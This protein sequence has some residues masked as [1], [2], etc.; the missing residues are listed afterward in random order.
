MRRVFRLFSLAIFLVAMSVCGKYA[1]ATIHGAAGF[2]YDAATYPGYYTCS[3]M[4]TGLG[5]KPMFIGNVCDLSF[6]SNIYV[7]HSGNYKVRAWLSYGEADDSTY[8]Y[9]DANIPLNEQNVT[10]T[11]SSRNLPQS[12]VHSNLDFCYYLIDESGNLYGNIK[13][14]CSGG[15]PLPP[16]PPVP[17]TS[18]SINNGNSLN[19]NLGTVERA[20]LITVPGTGSIQHIQIPVDCTGG[21]NVPVNMVI[22]YTPLTVSGT[23]IVKTSSNGLGVSIIY[24]NKPISTSDNTVI[25]FLSGSNVLD[26]GFE[27]VRDP[28]VSIADVPTG[29]FTASATI[30]MTQQ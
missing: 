16:N 26:L 14:F 9:F 1:M 17:P 4:N 10:V 18:C 2:N 11:S 13:D 5:K 8:A 30:I 28:K 27:A 3:Y 19:V 29:A 24:N 21:V 12:G 25:N 7:P 15:T 22:N 20:Q 6:P 23:Q